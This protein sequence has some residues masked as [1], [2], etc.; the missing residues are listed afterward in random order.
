MPLVFGKEVLDKANEENYAVGAFNFTNLE[1]LQAIIWA[2]EER[3]SPVIVQ[4]SEGAV[5]YMGFKNLVSLVHVMAMDSPVPIVLNLDHG[6]DMGIIHRCIDH[7]YTA[8]MFDGSSLEYEKNVEDTMKVVESAHNRKVSVEAELGMLGTG[9]DVYTDPEQAEDFVKRTGVDCLAVSIG[10]Q[11]GH[12]KSEPKLDF[13]RIRQIKDR[14]GIP[15]VMHGTSGVPLPDVKKAIKCG[16]NKVN[17]NTDLREAFT[18]AIRN[19]LADKSVYKI[20]PYLKESRVSVQKV[21]AK[22]MDNLGS[23][24]KA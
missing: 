4:T 1:T 23:S 17:L 18:F 13:D 12:F 5:S 3:K 9:E 8:V 19:V 22:H 20:R 24:K 21:V 7:G 11:H 14:L 10:T 16:I 2:A 15:L 6:K